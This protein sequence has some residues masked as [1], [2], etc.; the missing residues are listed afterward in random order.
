[1]ETVLW[2]T[3]YIITAESDVDI[4]YGYEYDVDDN[5]EPKFMM[6]MTIMKPIMMLMLQGSLR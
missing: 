6:L 1:M 4:I 3:L 2:D 5:N